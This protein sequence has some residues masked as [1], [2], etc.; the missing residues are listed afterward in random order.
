M[1]RLVHLFFTLFSVSA[2]LFSGRPY[3]V[4]VSFDGFRH[5]YASRTETPNFDK[6]AAVGVKA[7]SLKPVF[8]SKTFPN[9]Y[10]IATGMYPSRHGIL[11]NHF[12]DPMWDAEYELSDRDA[13]TDGR[14]Y[15]GE[16][17]WVTAEKQGVRAASYYWVGSEGAVNGIAPT[18]F[19]YYDELVPF[20]ER[21][22]AVVGWLS[23]PHPE[24][25]HLV[26]LYFHEPDGTG[27]N[28][29]PDAPETIRAIQD[30]DRTLGELMD[31]LSGLAIADSINLIVVS[32]HGMTK[33]SDA[34]VITL[35]RYID[36]DGLKITEGGATAL[37]YVEAK[38]I[39]KLKREQ[40]IESLLRKL[41][42]ASSHMAV[43]GRQEVPEKWHFRGN[44]RLPDILLVAEE[45]WSIYEGELSR[46]IQKAATLLRLHTNRG[47]H[48]YDND[49]MNMHTIFYAA[50]PA[51]KAGVVLPTVENINIYP[52]LCRLLDLRPNREI[53][54]EITPFLNALK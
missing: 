35:S 19:H 50:G 40:R 8:P 31:G 10:S 22:D 7:E 45:G 11:A 48:G 26:T 5:D 38:G 15:G 13:V 30:A 2:L 28:Y 4:L 16:P 14:W 9:H 29:G 20:T 33:V 49:L 53:D 46:Q 12:Y 23:R 36:L 18:Y 43:F 21:I 41:G 39:T 51:F 24:R 1:N 3:V 34:K 37:L 44:R 47:T 54:G 32:D 17:I 27:H 25:P 6:M 42:S 52:L